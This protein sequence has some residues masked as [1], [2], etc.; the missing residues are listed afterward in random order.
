ME[1]PP[2]RLATS[3]FRLRISGVD[4]SPGGTWRLDVAFSNR[5]R[6]GTYLATHSAL[7]GNYLPDAELTHGQHILEIRVTFDDGNYAMTRLQ[8]MAAA[9]DQLDAVGQLL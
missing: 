3:L 4:I 6:Q 2:T 7:Y 1:G 9:W 8:L 5:T